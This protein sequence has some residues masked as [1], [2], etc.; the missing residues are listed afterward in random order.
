MARPSATKPVKIFLNSMVQKE[1]GRNKERSRKRK[2]PK[3]GQ[4]ISWKWK[5]RRK[6]GVMFREY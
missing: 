5:K 3:E 4:F 6:A 2:R 1:R